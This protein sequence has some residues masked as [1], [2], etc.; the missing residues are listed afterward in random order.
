MNKITETFEVEYRLVSWDDDIIRCLTEEEV[1]MYRMSDEWNGNVNK[2]VK[3]SNGT[4][5]MVESFHPG[6]GV[7]T[8]TGGA[9][10]FVGTSWFKPPRKR[11]SKKKKK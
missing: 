7:S 10:G 11:I 4:W 2:Y 8:R 3:V 5:T 6:T 9:T 1:S